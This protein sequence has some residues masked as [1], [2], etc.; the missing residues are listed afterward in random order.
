MEEDLEEGYHGENGED[1]AEKARSKGKITLGG[2]EEETVR[3]AGRTV[4]EI[5]QASESLI[6]VRMTIQ[7][8][9]RLSCSCLTGCCISQVEPQQR[10]IRQYIG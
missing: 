5:L 8:F 7:R 3:Y 9:K 4:A 6:Q 10:S 2:V 1:L